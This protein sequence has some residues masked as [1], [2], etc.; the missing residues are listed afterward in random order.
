MTGRPNFL[1]F[2]TAQHR[3]DHLGCYGNKVVQTPHID[4][5]AAESSPYPEAAA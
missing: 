3:A 2:I 1:L 4:G 5:I